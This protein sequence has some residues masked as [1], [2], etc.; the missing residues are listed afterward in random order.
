MKLTAWFLGLS[1]IKLCIANLYVLLRAAIWAVN[2]LGL[3]VFGAAPSEI[4]GGALRVAIVSAMVWIAFRRIL[5]WDSNLVKGI[6][7]LA[8]RAALVGGRFALQLLKV[9]LAWI[10]GWSSEKPRGRRK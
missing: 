3:F 10:T 4:L 5:G 9:I 7:R 6:E 2:G 1:I 8:A